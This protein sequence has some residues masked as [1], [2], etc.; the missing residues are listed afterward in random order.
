MRL[1]PML[2]LYINGYQKSAKIEGE[3]LTNLFDW[4]INFLGLD[5][6]I[7]IESECIRDWQPMVFAD[8]R[9]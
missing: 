9:K 1:F 5:F 7:W 3:S 6:T 8:Y 4:R 2:C